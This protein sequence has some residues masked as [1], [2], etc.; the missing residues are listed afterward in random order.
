MDHPLDRPRG[1]RWTLRPRAE[2]SPPGRVSRRGVLRAG[3]GLGAV[4]GGGVL[5]GA[6]AQE[7]PTS[8]P[9]AGPAATNAL[10]AAFPQSVPHIAAGT[11]TRLP[12]LVS[13][14]EGVPLTEIAAPV[15]FVVRAEDGSEVATEVV[16]PRSDGVPRAY[17]PLVVTFPEPGVYDISATYEG[18]T[19][20]G[21][22]QAFPADDVATPVVGRRMPP[23]DTPVVGRSLEV[24]PICT[25]V[26]RCPFHEVDLRTALDQRRPVVLL[27][28]TPAYCATAVCG[29]ILENLVEL[30]GGR[31]DLAVIH[32]EVY[33]DPRSVSALADAELA[34]VP[35]E[36]QMVFEPA[37]FVTDAAGTVTA[38]ADVIVDRGEM[39]ELIATASA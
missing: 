23:V 10:L 38:R 8:T 33:K 22:V 6:C 35:K 37:L 25:L 13:D 9:E 4:A 24:D 5:L 30:M 28:S 34:P 17:L 29:P 1:T 19:L 36:W 20:D 18:S 26:P 14:P 32:S 15:E 11:P 31:D 27:V 7:G 21:A 2:G 3:L 16:R 39:A 12:Y